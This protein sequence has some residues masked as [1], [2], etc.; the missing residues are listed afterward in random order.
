MTD[1]DATV[2]A[3]SGRGPHG[4]RQPPSVVVVGGGFAGLFAARRLAHGPVQVR[5][6]DRTGVH[7]FQPLLYQ[8]ATGMLSEGQI[9]SPLRRLFRR[10][11]NVECLVA[12]VHDIDVTTRVV[13]ARRAD[14]T[15]LRVP[16]DHL[17]VAAGVQQSYFGHDKYARYAPGL[18]SMDDALVIRRR[19]YQAFEVAE[20]LP[21]AEQRRP[22]LTFVLVGAG[23][24]GVELAGQIRELA[25]RTLREEFRTIDP[26]EARVLLLDGGDRALASFSRGL[27]G[28]ATA[29]LQR[30]GVE[31]STGTRATDI[32]EGGVELTTGDGSVR[33]VEA[34]TVLW[35]A[36]VAA[37]PLAA[38]LAH[39]SG[40][41]QAPDG[42][43]KVRP[44]L[45]LPGHPEVFVVGDLMA[46]DG[47]PGVAETAM[48]AGWHAAGQVLH[49]VGHA[50]AVP[51]GTPFR[52]RDLGSAAYISRGHALLEAGPLRLS[53]LPGWIAWGLLHL[54][55]LT[56]YRNRAAALTSWL[57]TLA[58]GNRRER[59]FPT[60]ASPSRK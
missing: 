12:D 58:L 44:D 37:P 48:Q 32:D 33:R 50:G 10:H 59:A 34:R 20:A 60:V 54:A 49:A 3:A 47:L 14:G 4:E 9:S 13:H 6:L 43:L 35:T 29:T 18:K 22:W 7:L 51:A 19:V 2:A 15:E 55:F 39:A 57:T 40:A 31:L 25:T 11:R 42:R 21:T 26:G 52:Y 27:S 46:L 41:Q 16:Y 36:G 45:T 24:T 5:L 38:A 30:L 17:I 1:H 23:P 8:V 28:A 56:G 53:G